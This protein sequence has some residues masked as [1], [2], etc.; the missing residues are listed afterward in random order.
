MSEKKSW[1][2]SLDVIKTV[3][4]ITVLMTHI[5]ASFVILFPVSSPEFIWGNIIDSISRIG[6][7]LFVMVSGALFLDEDKSFNTKE[8]FKKHLLK[9]VVLLVVWSL[10]YGILYSIVSGV[11]ILDYIFNFAGTLYPHV[12]Y[13]YMII[14][15]Y[16]ITPVLRLFV[17]RENSKYILYFIILSVCANYVPAFMGLFQNIFGFVVS[18]YTSRLYLNFAS[19]YT[20]YFLLGWYLTNMGVKKSTKRNLVVLGGISLVLMIVLTQIFENSIPESYNYTYDNLSILPF[21]YSLGSFVLLYKKE[22]TKKDGKVFHF[23]SKFTFGIYMLHIIFLEI[24][25]NYVLPYRSGSVL[26]PILYMILLFVVIGPLSLLSSY[27]VGKVPYLK[28]LLYL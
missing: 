28:K 6:V 9:M 7:P 27:L 13:M 14:G 26:S 4:I 2:K 17:K 20:T 1:N 24:F 3:A 25:M 5:S 16:L 21:L 8:F 10:V 12:W 11:S 15:L 23:I 22:N 18:K 19:G